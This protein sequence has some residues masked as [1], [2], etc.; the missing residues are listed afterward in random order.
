MRRGQR[1][2]WGFAALAVF[3]AIIGAF[4]FWDWIEF[5]RSFERLGK[6][7]QGYLEYRH[8]ETQIVFVRLPAA[9][10]RM[11]LSCDELKLVPDEFS[12]WGG[13]E[14]LHAERHASVDEFLIAKYEVTSSTWRRFTGVLPSRFPGDESPVEQVSWRECDEFCRRFG[15]LLPTEVQWECACRAGTDE[16]FAF[17]ESIHS[18]LVNFDGNG[19]QGYMRGKTVSVSEMPP[20][21]FGIHSM[22]GNV[23]EW[24]RDAIDSKEHQRVMRG[25]S[26]SSEGWRCLSGHRK[27]AYWEDKRDD[28]G[29]RPVFEMP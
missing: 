24:C 4:A 26:W 23:A 27:P 22:H 7:Q 19:G 9:R 12:A 17:G 8:I 28:C 3:T 10:V 13:F 6:N 15:F 5:Q 16:P 21:A 2:A 18:D 20:N 25:G 11:G 1:W 14:D 29:F